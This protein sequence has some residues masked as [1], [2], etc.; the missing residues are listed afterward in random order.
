MGILAPK[1]H[2][3]CASYS[4]RWVLVFIS[5]SLN[6]KV[7]LDQTNAASR[8]IADMNY[9]EVETYLISIP[10]PLRAFIDIPG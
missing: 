5:L 2:L 6:K 9:L 3:V 1:Y 4:S 10:A 7:A 8:S